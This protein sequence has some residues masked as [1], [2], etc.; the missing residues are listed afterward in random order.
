MRLF[1]TLLLFISIQS[2]ANTDVI[3]NQSGEMNSYLKSMQVNLNNN[4]VMWG[5]PSLYPF[6]FNAYPSPAIPMPY[7]NNFGGVTVYPQDIKKPSKNKKKFYKKQEEKLLRDSVRYTQEITSGRATRAVSPKPECRH[8][9]P[10]NYTPLKNDNGMDQC[11]ILSEDIGKESFSKLAVCL[12]AIKNKVISGNKNTNGSLNRE[13]VFKA[14]YTNLTPAEQRFAALIFTAYGETRGISPVEENMAGVM[15]VIENRTR[16]VKQRTG[17]NDV[18]ELDI[19]LAPWQFSTFNAHDPNWRKAINSPIMDISN[20]KAIDAFIELRGKSFMPM[21]GA[22]EIYHFHTQAM[23]RPNWARNEP[24]IPF[25]VDG[26]RLDTNS[27]GHQFYSGIAFP[28]SDP[29][30]KS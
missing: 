22:E 9:A 23:G 5:D 19:A 10:S 21:P 15:K 16:N 11:K 1:T 4:L 29:P 18:N 28:Y 14:M 26:A 13:K 27:S 17:R 8:Y 2:I 24:I 6:T 25:R 20:S 12:G 3:H 30:W 7:L